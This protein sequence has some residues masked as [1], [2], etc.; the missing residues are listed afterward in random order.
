MLLR[1]VFLV[2]TFS[3]GL[4]AC[5]SSDEE[6]MLSDAIDCREPKSTLEVNHCMSADLREAEARLMK[7]VEVAREELAEDKPTLKAFD[8]AQSAWA[9]YREAHCDSVYSL[10]RDGT[11]RGSMN[12]G[13]KTML[14][15]ERTYAVWETF[16][17]K[18][19]GSDPVLPEPEFKLPSEGEGS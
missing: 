12:L 15:D 4:M 8:T 6:A 10:Y 14:T 5:S 11:I 13:C 2:G 3:F 19:D 18:L 9:S 1:G 7:Y 17:T 16:L